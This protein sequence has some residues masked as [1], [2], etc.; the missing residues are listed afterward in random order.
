MLLCNI[1]FGQF[2]GSPPD[3][4]GE[5]CKAQFAILEVRVLRI[6]PPLARKRCIGFAFDR[7]KRFRQ[8]SSSGSV[9]LRLA[10]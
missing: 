3:S 2:P 4:P 7:P 1:D 6:W 5:I 8:R 9:T 10:P